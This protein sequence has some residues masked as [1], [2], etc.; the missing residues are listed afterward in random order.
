MLGDIQDGVEHLLV[1]KADV[2]A[3]H[4]QV[5]RDPFGKNVC[6]EADSGE[7]ITERLKSRAPFFKCS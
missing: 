7:P 6:L 2:A 5:W 3:L 4:R 1:R